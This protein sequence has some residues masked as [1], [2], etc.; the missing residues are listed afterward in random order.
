[1]LGTASELDSHSDSRPR[2]PSF[3]HFE[4][5]PGADFRGAVGLSTVVESSQVRGRTTGLDVG[6]AVDKRGRLAPSREDADV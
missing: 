2:E 6:V 4:V 1:M 5:G 3:F